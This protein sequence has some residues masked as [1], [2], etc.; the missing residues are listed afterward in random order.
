MI[1]EGSRFLFPIMK[2]NAIWGFSIG[3]IGLIELL[4][5][6]SQIQKHQGLLSETCALLPLVE[7]VLCEII[8]FDSRSI[9]SRKGM[10]MLAPRLASSISH[11]P[12]VR[13][14]RCV[15][16][17]CL[18]SVTLLRGCGSSEAPSVHATPLFDARIACRCYLEPW[19]PRFPPHRVP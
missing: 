19:C 5:L 7:H 13:Q 8:V 3:L 11:L 17:G 9:F 4:N 12:D 6:N 1:Y 10:C 14:K 18:R 15:V 16:A 2:K